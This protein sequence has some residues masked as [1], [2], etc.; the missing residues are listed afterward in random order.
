MTSSRRRP[1]RS[2]PTRRR[3][4]EGRTRAESAAGAGPQGTRLQKVLSTAGVASRRA[5]EQL[6]VEGRVTVNGRVAARL[7]MR[8]DPERDRIEVDGQRVA[9][10]SR[11]SYLML[12]KPQGVVT[13]ARDP[14]GRPTVIDLVRSR[15][16]IYPVGRL[17]AETRGLVILTNDGPLAHRLT[18][19]RWEVPRVYLAKVHGQVTDAAVRRLVSGVRLDDGPARAASARVAARGKRRSQVELTMTEGRK[20][21]VRRMLAAVGHPVIELARVRFG[22]LSLKGLPEGRWRALT[23]QEVGALLETVGL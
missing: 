16:R 14:R 22:P 7:G 23:P 13:T 1:A 4:P 20:R 9:A 11:R 21:E 10:S 3:A 5:A 2:R 12:N 18:H 8:V 6:M 17:D 15:E 19:P